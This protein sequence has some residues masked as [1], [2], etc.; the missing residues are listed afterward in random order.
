MSGMGVGWGM[1]SYKQS[2]WLSPLFPVTRSGSVV[3]ES[4]VIFREGAFSASDVKSQLIQ[5]KK[6]ANNYNL[7]ISEVNGEAI[8]PAVTG[9]HSIGLYHLFTFGARSGRSTSFGDFP[10][11]CFPF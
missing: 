10:D 7:T 5:H 4:T 11:H 6:E 8:V 1:L 3:V 9:H 2:V